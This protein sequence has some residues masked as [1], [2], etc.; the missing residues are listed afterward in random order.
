M[1]YGR[2]IATERGWGDFK[3]KHNEIKFPLCFYPIKPILKLTIPQNPPFKPSV[4]PFLS[5]RR[6][7]SSGLLCVV[8]SF[9]FTFKYLS[10]QT[11]SQEIL[12]AWYWHE[13]WQPMDTIIWCKDA[14]SKRKLH[15]TIFF[16]NQTLSQH[17]SFTTLSPY[18]ILST[19]MLT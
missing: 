5:S 11:I 19:D 2:K 17:H 10:N 9:F 13:W 4:K 7:R 12:L 15:I 3:I 16:Y 1:S 18:D 6:E 8:Q 14:S